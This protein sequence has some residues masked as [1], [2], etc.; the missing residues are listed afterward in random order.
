MRITWRDWTATAL[1]AVA[2]LM[3]AVWLSE[4]EVLGISSPRMMALIVLGLGLVAS[5][6]AVVF[7]V[8]EGLLRANKLYL[9]ITSLIGLVALV[10][11]IVVLVNEN[12]DMLAVLVASTAVLWLISTVRHAMLGRQVGQAPSVGAVAG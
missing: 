9:A 1:V 10:A 4:G 8:G 7:G 3:Y 2:A 11:G 12:E 6:T 5:A